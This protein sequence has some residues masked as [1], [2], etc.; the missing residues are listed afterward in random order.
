MNSRRQTLDDLS[1]KVRLLGDVETEKSGYDIH[2]ISQ[3]FEPLMN[4]PASDIARFLFEI[5][6][7]YRDLEFVDDI[8]VEFEKLDVFPGTPYIQTQSFFDS[9]FY[10]GSLMSKG[11]TAEEAGLPTVPMFS[12]PKTGSSYVATVLAQCL[13]INACR[14]SWRN[15]NPVSCW[16]GAL[17]TFPSVT[18]DHAY[19]TPKLLSL[20]KKHG[21]TR[22]V[23]HS[24]EV[25][26]IVVSH[27]YFL[28]KNPDF[29]QDFLNKNY[30]GKEIHEII[31]D[32]IASGV[33]EYYRDWT[34]GW[35][36]AASD[37][38]ILFTNFEEMIG[39]ETEFFSRILDF[40]HITLG[41]RDAIL[42]GLD[43]ITRQS[44]ESVTK[45]FRLGRSDTWMQ[46]LTPAQASEIDRRMTAIDR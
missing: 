4:M 8:I 25:H 14:V 19:P 36:E 12:F 32:L 3:I 17:A 43:V 11:K 21:L 6:S 5:Q 7:H 15:V 33:V 45:N 24:R 10:C 37:F 22:L 41:S 35:K 2:R 30:V 34:I 13:N 42:S 27:G 18:H 16:V 46:D 29:A 39:G 44:P 40:L 38:D 1:H 20:L 26:A 31:D 28:K 23:V 9:L